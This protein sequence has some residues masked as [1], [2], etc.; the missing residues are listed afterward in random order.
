ML[1]GGFIYLP[2]H[3]L[4]YE[5]WRFQRLSDS[6][7]CLLPLCAYCSSPQPSAPPLHSYHLLVT[8]K[9]LI[10]ANT[11]VLMILNSYLQPQTHSSVPVSCVLNCPLKISIWMSMHTQKR[12]FIMNVSQSLRMQFS[13]TVPWN[14]NYQSPECSQT[15]E[16]HP[17]LLSTLHILSLT[18]A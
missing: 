5:I 14:H 11:C 10:F 6:L 8:S 1:Q 13:I 15:P 12:F 3:L 17:M 18:K 4:M 9:T 16:G 2:V 7:A